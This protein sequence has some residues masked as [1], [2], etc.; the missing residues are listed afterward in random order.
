MTTFVIACGEAQPLTATVTPYRPDAE[1]GTERI[2]G[3]CSAD[4]N[5]PG[6]VQLY[7]PPG[8][9]EALNCNVCPMQIG[10]LLLAARGTIRRGLTETLT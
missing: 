2:W 5:P 4:V 9:L 6:P 10:P 8:T 7:V 1:S 3:F